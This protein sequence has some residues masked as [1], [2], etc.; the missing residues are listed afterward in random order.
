M[1]T[2]SR[3]DAFKQGTSNL[4]AGTK[5]KSRKDTMDGHWVDFSNFVLLI[6]VKSLL[7]ECVGGQTDNLSTDGEDDR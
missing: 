7:E 6:G 1:H 2:S 5:K 4:D 3:G